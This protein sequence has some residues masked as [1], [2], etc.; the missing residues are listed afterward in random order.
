[1]KPTVGGASDEYRAVCV[2][3]PRPGGDPCGREATLHVLTE[4]QQYGL[5]ALAS[6]AGHALIARAA[7]R[8][9]MEHDFAGVCDLPGTIWHLTENRCVI[10][11]SGVEPPTLVGALDA[12]V[13]P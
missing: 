8:F 6:C 3:S 7:G 5:V 11:D 4:S 2:Y 12:A 13:S 10:D 9:V 1:M